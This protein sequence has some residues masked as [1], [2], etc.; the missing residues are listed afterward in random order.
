MD[1]PTQHSL[2]VM[3]LLNMHAC[4]DTQC[5]NATVHVSYHWCADLAHEECKRIYL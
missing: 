3:Q 1:I 5:K 2:L 4:M